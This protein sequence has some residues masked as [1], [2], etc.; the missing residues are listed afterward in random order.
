MDVLLKE[1]RW[2]AS[3]L[4]D[5]SALPKEVKRTMGYALSLAQEGGKHPSAKPLRGFGGTGVLE[6]VEDHQGD[7]YRAVY[8]VRFKEAVYL[9]HTFQKKSKRGIQTP[10]EE[11][12]LVKTRLK[13]AEADYL[14]WQREKGR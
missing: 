8:T 14:Q 6:V 11:I 1:F 12:A 5:L 3:A 4:K 9:L 13:V 2:V 10:Q 7:T